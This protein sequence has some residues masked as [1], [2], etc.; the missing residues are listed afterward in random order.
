M[1]RRTKRLSTAIIALMVIGIVFSIPLAETIDYTDTY[2]YTGSGTD[3]Y[4]EAFRFNMTGGYIAFCAD[5]SVY[6]HTNIDYVKVSLE[7]AAAE[8][9]L[10]NPEKV[11]AILNYSWNKSSKVEI[12]A[13][14][15]ALWHYINGIPLPTTISHYSEIKAIFDML[16]NDTLTPPIP[17]SDA[18]IVNTLTLT[19]PASSTWTVIPGVTDY[20]FDFT[21]SSS[22][23]AAIVFEALNGGGTPLSASAYD[24]VSLGGTSYRLTLHGVTSPASFTLQARS[25]NNK[26]VSAVAFVSFKKKDG[27][28]SLDKSKSQTVVGILLSETTQTKSFELSCADPTPT[29][30]P[31]TPTD[32]PPTPTDVPPTPTDVPPTPTDVPPTPTEVPPTPT[33]VPPTPT[34]VPPTPTDV[35]PTPTDVPPTPTEVPPTPTEVPPTPTEVPPTPT[36]VPPTPTEVPPT[37]TTEPT[38]TIPEPT[39]P[40]T[41]ITGYATIT[42]PP[43]PKTGGAD[44]NLLYLL[45]SALVAGGLM[46]K[47]RK[48][49]N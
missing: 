30:V 3:G 9:I 12:T 40:L 17:A 34:E 15:Y 39:I 37:P 45:G 41:T 20:S 18:S 2:R 6:I 24:V 10:T 32:V 29:V 42:E 22:T 36:E 47:R 23:G 14:Q 43:I 16:L 7:D 26:T 4:G 1:T 11:R 38:I 5:H 13:V 8:G 35:P 25:L 49:H 21:A 46:L 44:A 33:D 28:Y 27:V 19:G 31:P 48:N